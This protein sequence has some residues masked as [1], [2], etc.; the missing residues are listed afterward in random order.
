VLL[1]PVW[2]YKFRLLKLPNIVHG[3]PPE[4]YRLKPGGL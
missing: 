3:T 2:H 4:A 1:I